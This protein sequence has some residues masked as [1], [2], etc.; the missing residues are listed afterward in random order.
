MGRRSWGAF[1]SCSNL[2]PT[3][4]HF[5]PHCSL[6]SILPCC[7]SYPTTINGPTAHI[8]TATNVSSTHAAHARTY[9]AYYNGTRGHTTGEVIRHLH[10]GNTYHLGRPLGMNQTDPNYNMSLPLR[11]NGTDVHIHCKIQTRFIFSGAN[12]LLG[13]VGPGGALPNLTCAFPGYDDYSFTV[14]PPI[15]V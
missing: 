10:F 7:K 11:N 14:W 15:G 8:E 6:S 2:C 4:N 12:I 3:C 9:G 1:R 5:S 13:S